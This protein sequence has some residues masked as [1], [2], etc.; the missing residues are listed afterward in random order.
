MPA[1]ASIA[2]RRTPPGMRRVEM[3]ELIS[4]SENLA[5]HRSRLT[6]LNF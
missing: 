5:L 1:C 6:L 3:A 4:I 2:L